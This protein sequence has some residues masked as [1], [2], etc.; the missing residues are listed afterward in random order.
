MLRQPPPGKKK[1]LSWEKIAP[2][3]KNLKNK[4]PTWKLCANV[5]K[6]IDSKK[7][8]VP[9]MY[10]N[11]GRN[12]IL[13]PVL[14]SWMIKRLLVL[15]KN[16]IC[17]AT[18]LQQEIARKKSV[19]VEV[20]TIRKALRKQGYKW[21][22]RSKKPKYSDKVKA[23]RLAKAKEVTKMTAAEFASHFRFSLDG[24]IFVRPPNADVARENFC[25]AEETHVYRKASEGASPDLQGH[26]AYTKQAPLNRL[27]PLWGGIGPGGFGCV[28]WHPTRKMDSEEWSAAVKERLL[29]D[30]IRS[31][32]PDK[33]YGPWTVICDGEKSLHVKTL[34]FQY[35]KQYIK[36]W[37]IPAKCPDM[38]PV[39]KMW[40]WVRR[41]LRAHDF[42]TP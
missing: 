13:T 7:G 6:R 8:Y 27:L 32:N 17:T 41:Q 36:L 22:P 28:L 34:Q 19:K 21:L 26:D 24:V 4:Q 16:S 30:A 42:H 20:S 14:I 15:R 29:R 3:I 33:K 1:G 37:K 5:Y 38:N 10:A 31:V 11:C 39:E 9:Y 2:K 18:T 12:P 25:K 40:A 23:E 35:E